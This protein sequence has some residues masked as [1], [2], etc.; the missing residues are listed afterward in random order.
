MGT[1]PGPGPGRGGA[2]GVYWSWTLEGVGLSWSWLGRVGG[3][4]S[5]LRTG[6][7]FPSQN[8]D[9]VPL[10]PN[11]DQ[12]R[13]SPISGQNTAPGHTCLLRFHAGEL[14]RI[15]EVAFNTGHSNLIWITSSCILL[16]WIDH[17]L[18]KFND[19]KVLQLQ[20]VYFSTLSYFS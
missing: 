8:I 19:K 14:S 3:A 1:C 16:A 17:S 13:V 11:Q 18:V 12:D 15:F 4:Q 20:F 9:R 7:P 6:Y 5:G 2:R 10:P